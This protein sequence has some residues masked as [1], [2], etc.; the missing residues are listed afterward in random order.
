MLKT[1]ALGR[2][3]QEDYNKFETKVGYI[4]RVCLEN[5]RAKEVAGEQNASFKPQNTIK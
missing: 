5:P 4:G 3:R 1:L 2:L